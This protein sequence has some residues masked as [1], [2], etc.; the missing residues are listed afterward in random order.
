[1]VP[2]EAREPSALELAAESD[3]RASSACVPWFPRR[4][5]NTCAGEGATATGLRWINVAAGGRRG[6]AAGER[7][8]VRSWAMVRSSAAH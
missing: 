2:A 5:C 6:L 3:V 8:V 7:R 1:M 4:C